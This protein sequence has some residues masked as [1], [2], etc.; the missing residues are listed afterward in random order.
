M[1]GPSP[2]SDV[3]ANDRDVTLV[4]PLGAGGM[5]AGATCLDIEGAYLLAEL[6]ST[7]ADQDHVAGAD[8]DS[9]FPLPGVE[10]GRQDRGPTLEVVRALEQG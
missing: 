7:R 3:A 5:E 2:R 10:V 9:S 1:C 8:L 6:P 4:E